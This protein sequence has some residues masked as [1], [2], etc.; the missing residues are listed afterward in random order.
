MTTAPATPTVTVA[1][2]MKP[3][4]RAT[5][6]VVP[7]ADNDSITIWRYDAEGIRTPVRGAARAPVAGTF[8]AVDY[9]LPFGLPVTYTA[10]GFDTAGRPSEPS[11]PSA[12][13]KIDYTG[14]PVAM[15]P[16]DP[17]TAHLW[18]L[19]SWP[20]RIHDRDAEVLWPLASDVATVLCGPRRKP[21]S[22]MTVITRTA[23]QAAA[24]YRLITVPI[25][26][27]RCDGKWRWRAGYFHTVQV[28]ETPHLPYKQTDH[29]VLWELPLIPAAPPPPELH[30]PVHTWDEVA[31]LYA[32]W[33]PKLIG[34]VASWNQLVLNPKP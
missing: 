8:V 20:E 4:P 2:D 22:T 3:C 19:Q 27:I 11:N 21:G 26:Q 31:A 12:P 10:V 16:T 30:V 24:L 23:E 34:A 28:G 13:V 32:N 25:I 17:A 6:T 14:C 9:E 1:S 5:I 33:D 7:A 29:I 18:N 15:D